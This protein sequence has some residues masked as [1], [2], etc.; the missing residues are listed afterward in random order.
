MASSAQVGTQS[1]HHGVHQ[2]DRKT[3][4]HNQFTATE[5]Q[6]PGCSTG[7]DDRAGEHGQHA[8]EEHQVPCITPSHVRNLD[9]P[10]AAGQPGCRLRLLPADRPSVH[11]PGLRQ[12]KRRS[13][14][15][16]PTGSAWYH[17]TPIECQS[18]GRHPTEALGR[19]VPMICSAFTVTSPVGKNSSRRVILYQ[20]P[21]GP[22]VA[23]D[24]FM[25]SVAVQI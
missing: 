12:A 15:I 17:R 2:H 18:T 9:G 3:N 10:R 1:D 19:L 11:P 7:R 16:R 21:L 22:G 4:D 24:L 20:T 8:Q 14:E 25:Y 6:A 23:T 5:R 13:R